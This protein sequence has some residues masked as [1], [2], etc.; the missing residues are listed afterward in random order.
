M[1]SSQF[2][3]NTVKFFQKK[4]GNGN[5]RKLRVDFIL[6]KLQNGNQKYVTQ[7]IMYCTALALKCR[8]TNGGVCNDCCRSCKYD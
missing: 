4:I 2:Q 6:I 5:F 7:T 1:D 3:F 8:D